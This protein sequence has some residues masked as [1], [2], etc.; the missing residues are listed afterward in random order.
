MKYVS[1][2]G[3]LI[4]G[5]AETLAATAW[6]TDIDPL[7]GTPVYRGDTEVHWD[8]Q[9]TRQQHGQIIY[10]CEDGNEWT[11]DQLKAYGDDS[12]PTGLHI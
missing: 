2:N 11:F 5:T 7:T 6:I 10:V 1:P 4:T 3:T 9:Q 12:E 8:S